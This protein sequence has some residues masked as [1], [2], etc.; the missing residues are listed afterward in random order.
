MITRRRVQAR[1]S[2]GVASPTLYF[3]LHLIILALI[4]QRSSLVCATCCMFI[5]KRKRKAERKSKNI[6]ISIHYASV[7][8]S[9]E[10][11]FSVCS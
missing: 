9:V 7:H 5:I 3:T 8:F 1:G 10:R 4:Q 11:F 6:I 2:A